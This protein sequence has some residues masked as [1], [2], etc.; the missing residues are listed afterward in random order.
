MQDPRSE[1]VR[2]TIRTLPFTEANRRFVHELLTIE[3]F[4]ING[5]GSWGSA[6]LDGA[7]RDRHPVAYDAILRELNPKRHAR[8]IRERAKLARELRA[9]DRQRAVSERTQRKRDREMWR[10]LGGPSGGAV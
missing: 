5:P 1:F 6:I 9:E 8:E 3:R 7:L 10:R 4:V 2:D